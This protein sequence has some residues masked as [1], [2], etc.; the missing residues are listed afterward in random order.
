MFYLS[1]ISL[2]FFFFSSLSSIWPH[3][4][5]YCIVH[6][7][8]C[9]LRS[10]FIM[11]ITAENKHLQLP[12]VCM[13]PSEISLFYRKE[14]KEEQFVPKMLPDLEWVKFFNCKSFNFSF[15]CFSTV[16]AFH[17][18]HYKLYKINS[19]PH[20]FPLSVLNKQC[21]MREDIFFPHRSR[22]NLRFWPSC[23]AHVK[24]WLVKQLFVEEKNLGSQ[25][26]FVTYTFSNWFSSLCNI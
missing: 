8:F 10:F 5:L 13:Q 3:T 22:K 25:Y 4:F 14:T 20:L 11:C 6:K 18:L 26:I 19:P 9:F 21:G 2:W 23:Q 15:F 7:T 17:L 24:Y 1:I 16:L 12:Q